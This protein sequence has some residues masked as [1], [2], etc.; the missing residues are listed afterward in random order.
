MVVVLKLSKGEKA[1]PVILSLIDEDL[2]VLLQLLIDLLSLAVT[3]R[4]V[5]SG[6]GKLDS[7]HPVAFPGKLSHKL[8][9][10]VGDNF[11]RQPVVS[12]VMLDEE[13]GGS[14]SHDGGEGGYKVG[15]LGD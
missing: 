9:S 12:P 13:A 10:T 2:E 4:V 14:S 5:S 7:K 3:L 8:R 15:P 11:A 1:G 6:S